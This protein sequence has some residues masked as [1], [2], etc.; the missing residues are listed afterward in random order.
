MTRN[1]RTP[2]LDA[3]TKALSVPGN[4]GTGGVPI[5]AI[6]PLVL[7]SKMTAFR[8]PLEASDYYRGLGVKRRLWRC[9]VSEDP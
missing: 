5:R 8:R 9:S 1:C 2:A 7:N 3:H 6:G 4:Y